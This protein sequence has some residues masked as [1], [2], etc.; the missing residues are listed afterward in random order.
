MVIN[1]KID[2]KCKQLDIMDIQIMKNILIVI[3][4]DLHFA[5]NIFK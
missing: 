3:A 5:F 4:M 1:I 2:N